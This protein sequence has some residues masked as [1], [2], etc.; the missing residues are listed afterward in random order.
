MKKSIIGICIASTIALVSCDILTSVAG[1][2]LTGDG[3]T[4]VPAL[5][6]TEVI[7]G[8][9]EAL[10]V[11]IKNGAGNASKEDGFLKNDLIKLPFPQDAIAVKEKALQLGLDGQ[12]AKFEEVLNRAAESASKEAAPI[13][14]NA[15]KGMSIGDGFTIL[16][17]ADNAATDYLRQKTTTELTSA[18]A[19]KVEEAIKSV[20]LTKYWEPLTKAYNTANILGNKPDIN[21]DLNAFVT[22]R[23]IKGL[24]TLVESEELKIRKDPVARVSDILSKVFGSLD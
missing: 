1:E 12:V 2:V 14:I 6:N 22:E 9:K 3:T 20:N 16:K 17:G 5:T 10:T 19:P 24:F 13:F 23:A 15:I 4:G 11:G 18:F 21:T 7:S 8:L